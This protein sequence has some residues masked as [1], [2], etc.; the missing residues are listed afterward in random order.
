ML[1]GIV[2]LVVEDHADSNELLQAL[3]SSYGASVLSARSG[4]EALAVI[5]K[6]PPDVLLSDIAMPEM[7]GFALIAKIRSHEAQSRIARKETLELPAAA[8][9]AHTSSEYRRKIFAA[10]FEFI[11]PKPIDVDVLLKVVMAL[12]THD[13]KPSSPAHRKAKR[14]L[15]VDLK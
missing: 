7:D 12:A 11:V 5:S 2:V 14:N 9:T 8:I 3:L 6:T 4:A 13:L 1:E 10:G 15:Y